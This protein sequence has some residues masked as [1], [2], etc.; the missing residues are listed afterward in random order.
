V[1]V[2]GRAQPRTRCGIDRKNFPKTLAPSLTTGQG[3][4]IIDSKK[5]TKNVKITEKR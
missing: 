2:P 1:F 3:Y 4:E 5:E